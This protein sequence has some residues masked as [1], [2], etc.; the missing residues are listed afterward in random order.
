MRNPPKFQRPGDRSRPHA[1]LAA[2]QMPLGDDRF[3]ELIK[4]ASAFFEAAER[5]E[6]AQRAQAIEE[7]RA[8]MAHYDLTVDDLAD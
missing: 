5:D 8:L 1:L 2:R 7:I 3:Q 6:G 4:G